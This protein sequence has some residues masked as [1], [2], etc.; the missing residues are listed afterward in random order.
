MTLV[1]VDP[2]ETPEPGNLQ[3]VLRLKTFLRPHMLHLLVAVGAMFALSGT[4]VAV[5]WLIKQAFDDHISVGQ[6]S[7]LELLVIAIC[8]VA[9]AQFASTYVHEGLMEYVYERVLLAIRVALFRHLQGLSMSYFDRTEA[10]KV[11]SRIQNDV[12]QVSSF[13]WV[14]VFALAQ[15]VTLAGVMISMLA[16]SARLALLTFAV[17]PALVLGVWFW[18]RF[19][20]RAYRRIREAQAFLNSE[21]QETISGIRVVQSLNRQDEGFRRLADAAG[22]TRKA[23]VGFLAVGPAVG[24]S[25]AEITPA[26]GLSSLVIFG[27]SMVL[28]GSVEVGVVI[29]FALYIG[30]FMGPLRGL[31]GSYGEFRRGMIAGAR[32]FELLEQKSEVADRPDAPEIPPIRGEVRYEGVGFHY[33]P[34]QPV[35]EDV[36]L[37]V[38]PG[39]TVAL[40]GPT[41]AGKTTVVSLLLR[42]YQAVH[43]RITVDGHDIRAVTRQSLVSQMSIVLQEPYLFSGTVRDNIRFNHSDVTDEQV[44]E[45][46]RVVG[47]HDFIAKMED[48]Y[49]TQLQERGG[50]LSVGQRQ[51]VSFA[52]AL[53]ADPRILILDEATAYVDT[54]TELLI[55]EALKVLL[56]D[57]TALVIAHRLS[58]VRHADRIVVIDQ[59]R[60]VEQGTHEE[61]M[62]NDGLY[63]RLQTYAGGGDDA[64]TGVQEG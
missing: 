34:G 8:V 63:A 64:E 17:V 46:A 19:A 56:R 38:A 3:I 30:S 31:T 53:A 33:T 28:D 24:G 6:L 40:V 10:G 12:E 23:L 25:I 13:F 62:A 54:Q 2:E 42:L 29:A 22:K 26:V 48:G 51:L 52:R 21:L 4:I 59:G 32:I 41:G 27:G 39:E 1:A 35:L 14:G 47:A 57:R 20:G 11:M 15:T 9:V 37:H 45:A 50:N 16:M 7:G 60:I 44:M 58:T 61:L 55:Q 5:P 49:D 43:G 36:D 18:Y